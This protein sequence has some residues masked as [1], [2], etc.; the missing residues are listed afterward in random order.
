MSQGKLYERFAQRT[1]IWEFSILKSISIGLFGS[2]GALMV[3][4]ILAISTLVCSHKYKITHWRVHMQCSFQIHNFQYVV[5]VWIHQGWLIWVLYVECVQCWW[6]NQ[7]D[8]LGLLVKEQWHS[9]STFVVVEFPMSLGIAHALAGSCHKL[10]SEGASI[11]GCINILVH[12][13]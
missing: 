10:G 3:S 5:L 2:Q 13:T 1:K 4:S 9:H 7:V 11:S 6:M 8:F 12:P